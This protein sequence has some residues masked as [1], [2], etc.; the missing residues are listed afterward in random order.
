MKKIKYLILILIFLLSL[1]VKAI[2]SCTMYEM[3]RLK[4]L[5][6]NV[7]FTYDYEIDEDLDAKNQGLEDYFWVVYKLKG[8]NLND[9]LRIEIDSINGFANIEFKDSSYNEINFF[10]GDKVVFK[11]YSRTINLC[12]DR[13]LRTVTVNLP[14]YN[15]YYFENKEK[16]EEYSDFKYCK[17]FLDYDYKYNNEKID[18]LFEE[19][20]KEKNDDNIK[21]SVKNINYYYVI[22]IISIIVISIIVIVIIINKKK[23]KNRDI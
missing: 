17:E 21:A 4:E 8:I 23:N 19:Y 7:E 9:D 10:D 20:L 22:C 15:K 1:D 5:A 6:D 2:D 14:Y 3:T 12:T 11:I 13:L 18:K 16:C